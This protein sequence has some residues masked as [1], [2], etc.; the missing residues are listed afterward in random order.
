VPPS[1]PLIFP[2]EAVIHRL[3]ITATRA[4]D[5]PGPDAAGFDDVLGE[6][7]GYAGVGGERTAPRQEMAPIRVKCQVET[8]T[9]EELRMI[10]TGNDPVGN[11]VLVCH[12]RLLRRQGLIDASTGRCLLKSGDRI[13]KL[14]RGGRT[15]MQPVKP[16]YVYAVLPASWGLG[17]DGYDLEVVYTTERTAYPM[18]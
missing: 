4:V 6:P 15:V 14:E 17:A 10:F 3:D 12:R 1:V 8:R 9:F 2:V 18:S 13:E 7:L 16:L 11:L 5:P